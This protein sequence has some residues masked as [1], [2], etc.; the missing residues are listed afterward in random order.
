MAKGGT[1]LVTA[2]AVTLTACASSDSALKIRPLPDRLAAATGS[3]AP[4]IAEARG[5][6]AL[7]SVGL[8]I[9]AFRKVLRE[10]PNNAEAMAGLAGC[11]ER[12][13]R[14]D[15]A[16]EKYEAALAIAPSNVVLLNTF[17]ASLDHQGFKAQAVALRAEASRVE[18]AKIVA[19]APRTPLEQAEVQAAE[20][21]TNTASKTPARNSITVALP[22]ARP[23]ASD[24]A[25]NHSVKISPAVQPEVRKPHL[26]LERLS[27]GEVAL[28]TDDTPMWRTQV[29]AQTLQSVTVR[30]VRFKAAQTRPA[31]M[32][33]N[34]AR[35][36]GL[37]ARTRELLAAKGWRGIEI[38]DAPATRGRSMVF[39]PAT[40]R[41]L[42]RLVA[43]QFGFE[44]EISN[45]SHSVVVYL[46]RD[47][48]NRQQSGR[49]L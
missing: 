6:L 44:S 40:R 49:H 48:A 43:A 39:Y 31:V 4:M 8:A 33:L 32:L 16:R 45:R 18:T 29:V 28:R 23:A 9:E 3:D 36:Q 19:A 12:M 46:G 37:A 11:Y 14:Y 1:I 5:L 42:G 21:P 2:V 41:A 34:A 17:A 22:P 26:R 15:L 10:E 47:A 38:G 7:G 30:F 24:P 13:G 20:I 27:P 35:R 25:T